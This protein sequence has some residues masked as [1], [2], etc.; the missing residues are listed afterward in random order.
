MSRIAKPIAA[1]RGGGTLARLKAEWGAV[2]GAE[3]AGICWPESLGRDGAL[4][5]RCAPGF[6]L[7]LQHCTPVILDRI[8][9]F[10]GKASVT[11]VALVQGPLPFTPARRAA[12]PRAL[13]A[14]EE[15]ALN[16]QLQKVRDPELRDALTRL[17]R[18]LLTRDRD[19]D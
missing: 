7:D 10:C 1:K 4:K 11:R 14:A 8:T 13:S 2:V 17:G 18:S 19:P 16:H 9:L 12:P 15:G 6:A 5:L 3:L